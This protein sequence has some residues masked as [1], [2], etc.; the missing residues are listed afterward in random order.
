MPS[1]ASCPFQDSKALSLR[2]CAEDGV[3]G[4]RTGQEI[5]AAGTTMTESAGYMPLRGDFDVEVIFFY[6]ALQNACRSCWAQH[7]RLLR[8]GDIENSVSNV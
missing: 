4:M 5:K 1:F 3:A 7:T 8:M 2:L 6:G